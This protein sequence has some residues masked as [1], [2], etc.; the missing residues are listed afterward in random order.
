MDTSEPAT[1]TRKVIRTAA[2]ATLQAI[3]Y[4]GLFSGFA[5]ALY[6]FDASGYADTLYGIGL[7]PFVLGFGFLWAY[8]WVELLRW[9]SD[10]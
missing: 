5:L 4:A 2:A 3:F 6:A 7:L 8:C 10:D 1:R 9:W